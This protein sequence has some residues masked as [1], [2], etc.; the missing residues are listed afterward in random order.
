[1]GLAFPPEDADAL[2]LASAQRLGAMTR[3]VYRGTAHAEPPVFRL[4]RNIW[5]FDNSPL[6]R[7]SRY[8]SIVYRGTFS[9]GR[10]PQNPHRDGLFSPMASKRPFF[11]AKLTAQVLAR[12]PRLSRYI[13]PVIHRFRARFVYRG[14]NHRLSRNTFLVYRGTGFSSIAEHTLLKRRVATTTYATLSTA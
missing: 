11:A 4:S 6:F 13:W 12:M 9:E 3:F 7:L 8:V 10:H 1:M 2:S 14:T 5:L